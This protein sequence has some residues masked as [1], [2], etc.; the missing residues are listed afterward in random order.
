MYGTL[1]A[2]VRCVVLVLAGCATSERG[3]ERDGAGRTMSSDDVRNPAVDA[4]GAFVAADPTA[5]RTQ[6]AKFRPLDLPPPDDV[7]AASGAP[8]P[9]YW[10]QQVD[11]EIE[12]TLDD[13]TRTV[14]GRARITYRNRS[15]EALGYLWLHLEQNLFAPDSL[16]A[17]TFPKDARFGNT[18][19]VAGGLTLHEVL[20]DGAGLPY[21]VYD[22]LCRVELPE[23]IPPR[24]G[25]FAFE[26]AWSFPIPKEGSDR[27]G[28][29]ETEDGVI[30]EVAQW[31]PAVVKFDDVRGWNAMPYLGPGEFYTD[32]GDFDVRL[33]V[34]R[35]HVVAATGALTNEAEVLSSAAR[36]RLAAARR[37][38]AA[39][40]VRDADDVALAKAS[41]ADGAAV[42]R[43]SAKNVRTFAWASSA[44]FLWDAA[45]SS[46]GVLCQSFYPR[47]ALP[48]W[49]GATDM[50]RFSVEHYGATWHRYPYPC[51]SN[52]NGVVGGME[53]PGIVFCSERTDPDELWLVTTHEIGHTWF[54]MLV[55]NDERRHAWMDE[56][57]NTFINVLATR[58]RFPDRPE[59]EAYRG[60]LSGWF[61]ADDFEAHLVDP[62]RVPPATPPDRI[63]PDQIGDT[64]YAKPAYGLWLLRE[65]ILGRE[66]FDAAFRE[67]VSRW[68]FKAPQPADFF[69]TME[70]AAGADLAWFWRGWFLETHAMDFAVAAGPPYIDGDEA[71][72]ADARAP[73]AADE[74]E[75][76]FPFQVVDV[77]GLPMPILYAITWSDGTTEARRVPVDAWARQDRVPI[78]V[79][80]RAPRGRIAE[81]RRPTRVVLDPE[82]RLPDVDRSNDVADA[83]TP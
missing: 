10:Q 15:P 57:F 79:R 55:N 2:C 72:V 73:G 28:W 1:R 63:P 69:R 39:T 61:S 71:A 60:L 75:Y 11:Y 8:G 23:P 35:S 67:Y 25:T 44:A 24:D 58:A 7:R 59:G 48:A 47:A 5:A 49:S 30:Y 45:T 66:R 81:S 41:A 82:K 22:T 43:F 19:G 4:A 34:P 9:A 31:F 3:A 62:A 65:E 21:R 46:D 33:S 70:N 83:P 6:A 77:G 18:A 56:G 29:E 40:V 78:E 51:A 16:G 50:L 27:M 52:V 38:A 74:V 80:V 76:V 12:A 17:L 14:H 37:S 42:W 13:A 26:V 64:Q 53:Y 32:F 68:A 36:E 54:P 20:S